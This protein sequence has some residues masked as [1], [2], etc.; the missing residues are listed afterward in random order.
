MKYFIF[1]FSFFILHSSVWAQC[2]F[3]NGSRVEC[4]HGCDNYTDK[5]GKGY[6]DYSRSLVRETTDAAA[7]KTEIA[8]Q[9]KRNRNHHASPKI[10]QPIETND[11]FL[12]KS[13]AVVK[14]IS[15]TAEAPFK[16]PY[17]LIL[18]SALTLGGYFLTFLL[19]RIGLLH[20]VYHRRIWNTVL[21]L[22]AAV[23]CLFGFF[24][25]IQLNYGFLGS[26][27]RPILTWHVECG[28][29]MTII[30][31]FHVIW[32]IPYYKRLFAKVKK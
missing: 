6:C 19:S 5:N 29:A 10:Q 26:W 27:Y 12:N 2:P 32:H 15:E 9:R 25:A 1:Y 17:R 31:V 22:A 4:R 20:K 18:I 8:R 3:G 7:E 24:L 13:E 28:I 16:K 14:E 21:L 11:T 23:S 30:A